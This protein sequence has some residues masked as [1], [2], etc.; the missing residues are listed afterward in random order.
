MSS[1]R[2]LKGISRRIPC[3]LAW[4]LLLILSSIYFIFICPWIIKELSIYIPIIQGFIF[5]IVINNLILA[6]FTDPGR[7]NRA[8]QDENDDSETAFHKTGL[9]IYLF[10][11][12]KKIQ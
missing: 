4:S 11:L 1:N 7:Y 3:F 12:K 8:P 10:F 6:I 9:V 5:L 2:C